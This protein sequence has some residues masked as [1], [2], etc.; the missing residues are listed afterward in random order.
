MSSNEVFSKISAWKGLEKAYTQQIA[1]VRPIKTIVE[2]GVDYGF[3]L[4]HFAQDFPD[5]TV[6]GIDDYDSTHGHPAQGEHSDAKLWVKSFLPYFKNVIL[7]NSN[8]TAVAKMLDCNIDLLHI[9]AEHT[10]EA[11]NADFAAWEPK[12]R[13]GGCV[14]FHDTI[15]F[16]NDIGRFFEELQGTKINIS[17]GAGLG[18]WFKSV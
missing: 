2:V 12:V 9:D 3:S 10:Y 8:S 5:A 11:V 16:P 4:F 1:N 15:S 13:Q 14:M 18:C 17:V 6:I 7:I